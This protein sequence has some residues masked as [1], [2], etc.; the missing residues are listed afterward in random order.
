MRS[1]TDDHGKLQDFTFVNTRAKSASLLIFFKVGIGA[2]KNGQ[3]KLIKPADTYLFIR[4]SGNTILNIVLFY[5]YF[6]TSYKATT[7]HIAQIEEMN[8]KQSNN[9]YTSHGAVLKS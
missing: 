4:F 8:Y 9:Q 1:A 2:T 5:H 3:F 6:Y 7:A